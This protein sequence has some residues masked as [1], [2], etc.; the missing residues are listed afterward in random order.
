MLLLEA[1]AKLD[2]GLSSSGFKAQANLGD[3]RAFVLDP[4][5]GVFRQCFIYGWSANWPLFY[6]SSCHCLG[7]GHIEG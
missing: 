1:E 6:R 2:I 4:I 5:Q 3:K 7:H